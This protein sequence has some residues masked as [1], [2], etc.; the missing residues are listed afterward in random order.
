MRPIEDLN[1]NESTEE[2]EKQHR[3]RDDAVTAL[4]QEMQCIHDILEP[5]RARENGAKA[6]DKN[7]M[8]T[9]GVTPIIGLGGNQ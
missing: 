4:R 7:L 2:L 5:R 3:L 8:Q 1:V 9:F 6:G